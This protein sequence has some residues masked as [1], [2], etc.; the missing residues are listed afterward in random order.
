MLPNSIFVYIFIQL[1]YHL[2]GEVADSLGRYF[3]F[4]IFIWFLIDFIDCHL[5]AFFSEMDH[6]I[7]TPRL[8]R[9]S[10]SRLLP[11]LRE[12]WH[13]HIIWRMWVSLSSWK[14]YYQSS[15][16]QNMKWKLQQLPWV[17]TILYGKFWWLVRSDT[18]LD[19]CFIWWPLDNH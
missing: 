10:Q 9:F 11:F 15:I 7:T 14:S 17:Y 6:F 18:T 3:F 19:C 1:Y 5:H 4:V 16:S 13:C 2:Y 12:Q 8:H